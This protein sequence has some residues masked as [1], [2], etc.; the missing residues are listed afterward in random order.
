[1]EKDKLQNI[2]KEYTKAELRKSNILQNPIEQLK[3]W[4]NDAIENNLEEPNAMVLSTVDKNAKPSSR[5][6]LLREITED[7]ILFY[8]NYNSKKAKSIADNENVCVNIFW[9]QMQ[10]QVRIEGTCKKVSKQKSDVY[11]NSRPAASRL[12]SMASTQ[13]EVIESKEKLMQ[14]FDAK[15]GEFENKNIERPKNWGGFQIK[16]NYIEFWKGGLHRLHDR[17]VFEKLEN[18][19]R[20]NRLAP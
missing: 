14:L 9:Q 11:F 8:T 2:R 3:L 4:V 13:S 19:W 15:K 20:L 1:M 10:R 17:L 6:V 7:S 5:V 12:A 18:N 16:I